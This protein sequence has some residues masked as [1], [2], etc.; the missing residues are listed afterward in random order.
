[1]VEATL[2]PQVFLKCVDSVGRARLETSGEA[3]CTRLL[4]LEPGPVVSVFTQWRRGDVAAC[5]WPP[6]LRMLDASHGHVEHFAAPGR[7]EHVFVGPQGGQLAR[8]WHVCRTT[9]DTMK[10]R[11]RRMPS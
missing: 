2:P 4:A 7:D 8:N 6:L 3:R 10:G 9:P 11:L 1:M 5:P